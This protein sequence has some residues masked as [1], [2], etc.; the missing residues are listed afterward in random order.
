[1][2]SCKGREEEQRWEKTEWSPKCLCGHCGAQ[3]AERQMSDPPNGCPRVHLTPHAPPNTPHPT[4]RPVTLS[5]HRSTHCP[6]R[7]PGSTQRTPRTA[8]PPQHGCSPCTAM[9]CGAPGASPGRSCLPPL[10]HLFLSCPQRR[11]HGQAGS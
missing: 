8:R 9:S 10:P 5:Q 11:R 6:R 1:M 4:Q 3:R 7:S 2:L